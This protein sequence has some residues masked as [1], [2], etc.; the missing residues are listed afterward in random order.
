MG[1]YSPSSDLVAARLREISSSETSQ[2]RTYDHY[3][4]S[5]GSYLPD[6][7]CTGDILF[8]H[9]ISLKGIYSFVKSSDLHSHS[10]QYQY[11]IPDIKDFRDVG[12]DDFFC[13]QQNCADH[14]QSLIL[15]T[16]RTDGA[17]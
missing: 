15:C 17:A 3:G 12:N 10:L 4:S 13:G 16:L 5:E 2:K 9:I 6:K 8:I 11:Q 14:L 1:I 7:V